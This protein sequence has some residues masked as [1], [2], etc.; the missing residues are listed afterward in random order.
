MASSSPPQ[1]RPAEILLRHEKQYAC[2]CTTTRIETI[3][4][5]ALEPQLCQLH[6]AALLKVVRTTEY[7]SSAITRSEDPD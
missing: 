1:P 2:G 5:P 6:Q 7:K 4:L 3:L